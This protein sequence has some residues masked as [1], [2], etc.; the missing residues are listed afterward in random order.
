[1]ASKQHFCFICEKAGFP[2]IEIQLEKIGEKPDGRPKWRFWD[3]DGGEHRHKG[4]PQNKL[5][6]TALTFAEIN[7]KLDLILEKLTNL[8]GQKTLGNK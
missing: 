2:G 8:E 6:S 3:M 7:S 4:D 1:M 5:P